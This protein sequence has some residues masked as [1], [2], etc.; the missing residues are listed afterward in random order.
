MD[1]EVF[2]VGIIFFSVVAIVKIIADANFRRRLVEKGLADDAVRQLY[3]ATS[4]SQSMSSLKWGMVLVG[5]G[6]AL[7][8]GQFFP[9]YV[10]DQV[11]FGLMFLFA[12]IGF[13]IYYPIA[14][15]LSKENDQNNQNNQKTQNRLP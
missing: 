15:S 10:N 5:M 1:T 9:H 13:L 3:V 6:A 2:V 12:G 14:A 7:L 11:T 8:I 4:T